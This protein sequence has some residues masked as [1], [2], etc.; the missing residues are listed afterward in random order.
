MMSEVKTFIISGFLKKNKNKIIF[1]KEV[2]ALKKEDALEKIYS[3]L[4]GQIKVPRR[5]IKITKIEEI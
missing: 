2:K 1:N 3:E 5:M 4:G